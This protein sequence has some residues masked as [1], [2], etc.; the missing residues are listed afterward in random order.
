MKDSG[1]SLHIGHSTLKATDVIMGDLNV[2]EPEEGRFNVW[3]Q[4]FTEG[5]K[6]I[7]ALFHYFFFVSSKSLNP[8]LQ[9]ETPQPMAQY[10]HC[11]GLIELLMYL[12]ILKNGPYPVTVQQYVSSYRNRLC[13]WPW[14]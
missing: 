7:A 4:T 11:P 14:T 10:V 6:G 12:R 5:D 1:L 9:G 2:C 13:L 8:M 3:N